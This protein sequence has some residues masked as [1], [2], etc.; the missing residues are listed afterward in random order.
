MAKKKSLSREEVAEFLREDRNTIKKHLDKFD[1]MAEKVKLGGDDAER[2]FFV[3]HG[4]RSTKIL[5]LLLKS[6]EA[7]L[8]FVGKDEEDDSSVKEDW[9]DAQPEPAPIGKSVFGD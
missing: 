9:R 5:E 2:A 8:R 3:C 4:S 7:M 1:E 6:N